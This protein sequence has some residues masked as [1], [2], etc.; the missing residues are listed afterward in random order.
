MSFSDAHAADRTGEIERAAVLYEEAISA[1]SP[2]LQLLLDLALLYWQATDPGV[3]AAKH[4]DAKFLRHAGLRTQEL[5]IQ[6][7]RAFPESTA[8]RFWMRYIAWA[9]LC[10]PFDAHDCRQLLREDPSVRLPAMHVF[11]LSGGTDMRDEARELLANSRDEGTAGA[12]YVVS[13]I[14][15]VMKRI[16]SRKPHVE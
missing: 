16:E 13:V 4:L 6:A 15:G 2:S 5:L 7:A 10:E 8:V 11:A 14:E 3:A 1:G 9:D 12:R